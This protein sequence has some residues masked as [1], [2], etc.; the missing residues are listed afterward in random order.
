MEADAPTHG[1]CSGP[2][3]GLLGHLLLHFHAVLGPDVVNALVAAA[4]T[5]LRHAQAPYVRYSLLMGLV[6]LF[7]R[8]AAVLAHPTSPL[9]GTI[10]AVA[11]SHGR[12]HGGPGRAAQGKKGDVQAMSYVLD[13]WCSLH[14]HLNSRY[15]G[16]ISSLGFLELIKIFNQHAVNHAFA[17]R[18]LR[19]ALSTLPRLL[20]PSAAEPDDEDGWGGRG[21]GGDDGDEL[22][23]SDGDDEY[24]SDYDDEWE[25]DDGGADGE[26]ADGMGMDEE[27]DL[28]DDAAWLS[29]RKK[30]GR[31]KGD[32]VFAPAEMYLSDVLD[33][34][35][36]QQQTHTSGGKRL[37][38]VL[39]AGG[40]GGG[41]Y[42]DEDDGYTADQENTLMVN[43][44]SSL[45][46]SPPSRD[47]LAATDLEGR[48]VDLLVGLRGSDGL[49]PAWMGALT[50]QEQHLV[51]LLATSR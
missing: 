1:E 42:C 16:V 9:L 47:P 27:G 10:P 4:L 11:A 23:F 15:C 37:S 17:L 49:F 50:P 2:A 18:V 14:G 41:D 43:V 24:D 38:A 8:N 7:A 19:L 21:L 6:H 34:N 29:E 40:A 35:L 33:R 32:N 48:V 3:A 26:D 39:R 31:G 28:D 5:C 30:K 51:Q 25:D 22:E 46:F 36:D 13:Q 44:S 45:M 20:D 12:G